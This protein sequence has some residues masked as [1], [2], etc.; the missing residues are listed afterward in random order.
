MST[1]ES[2]AIEERLAQ[3]EVASDLRRAELRALLDE[4]PHA[5]SRRSLFS[6]AVRDLRAAPAKGDI[7]KRF[8]AKL[9]RI[10]GGLVRRVRARFR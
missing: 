9:G 4:L 8:V 3:L 7:A 10:P 2:A 1:E 6:A 5:V